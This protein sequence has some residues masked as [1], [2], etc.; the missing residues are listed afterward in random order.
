MA[1]QLVTVA[2]NASL[3]PRCEFAALCCA[4]LC[5]VALGSQL[6]VVLQPSAPGAIG[7]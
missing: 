3:E 5:R 7:L 4:A 2:E 6:A 1:E